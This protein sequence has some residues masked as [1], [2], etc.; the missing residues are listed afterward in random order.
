[1]TMRNIRGP[2]KKCSE[3]EKRKAIELANKLNDIT[4]ASRIL[5]I[6]IKNLKRWI[7]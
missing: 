7:K 5:D 6:P 3:E 4:A 2:Y 1:M